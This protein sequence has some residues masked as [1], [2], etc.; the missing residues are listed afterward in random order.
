LHAKY[1]KTPEKLCKLVPT[2]SVGLYFSP[3]TIIALST[4]A[5]KFIYREVSV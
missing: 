5:Q 1:S 4:G 2:V 3:G